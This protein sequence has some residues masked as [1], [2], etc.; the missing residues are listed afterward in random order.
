[1][2]RRQVLLDSGETRNPHVRSDLGHPIDLVAISEVASVVVELEAYQ[3]HPLAR[4]A[5]VRM[6]RRSELDGGLLDGEPWRTVSRQYRV[7]LRSHLFLASE[8]VT[9]PLVTNL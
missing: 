5:R 1:V 4:V 8:H 3:A 6:V 2:R 9:D 7:R